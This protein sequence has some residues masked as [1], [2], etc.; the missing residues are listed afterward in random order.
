MSNLTDPMQEPPSGFNGSDDVDT[1]PLP[2]IPEGEPAGGGPP[3]DPAQRRTA[4]WV[5]WT[6]V[7]VLAAA[8]AAGAAIFQPMLTPGST[9]AGPTPVP[10]TTLPP[11]QAPVTDTDE[12]EETTE[13]P[14][15]PG[16]APSAPAPPAEPSAEPT[17]EPTATTEPTPEPTPTP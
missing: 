2:I 16:P 8:L 9:P 3:F 10:S 17:P 13:Q 12:G 1:L 11:T 6:L 15:Q 4:A 14:A 5:P 7:L